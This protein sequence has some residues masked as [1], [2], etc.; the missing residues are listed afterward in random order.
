MKFG[1][2]FANTMQFT[3]REGLVELAQ[4]AEAVG[5]ESLWTVEHVIYPDAYESEYPYDRSGKMV[6]APETDLPDPLIWLTWVAAVTERIHLGTG[7]LILPQRNPLVLAKE[8]AT[9]DALAGGRVELGI[10]VG[11]L[12]EEFDALGVPFAGRGRRTDEYV[13]AMRALW[14]G[15]HASYEGETVSF[16]GASVNPKPP[17]GRVPIHVGGHTETSARRAGRL[18]DG[19]FPGKGDLPTLIDIVRQ[20]AADAGRDPEAIEITAGSAGILGEDP[21]GAVQ[22][23]ADQ[24]VDR[25]V[26]PSFAFLRSTTD[27]LAAFAERAIVPTADL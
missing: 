23:L 16:R 9:L 18:G 14:D 1:I 5:F 25:V 11:W 21:V 7:I 17:R 22:E 12:E 26:V 3:G 8:V 4:G 20:T 15:D 13:G 6:M 2:I 27:D 19:Y 24:G 10:G